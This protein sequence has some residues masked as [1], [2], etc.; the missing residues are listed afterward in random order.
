MAPEARCK[1]L[2]LSLDVEPAVPDAL[3]GDPVRLRQVVLN[4]LG[5][6][7]KFTVRGYIKVVVHVES[8]GGCEVAL[9]CSVRDSGIGVP[10]AQQELIF[11]PFYQVDGAAA[12]KHS[13]T[14]LGLAIASRLVG[15][16]RG[17]IWLESEVGHGSAFHFTACLGLAPSWTPGDCGAGPSNL[18]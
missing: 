3:L 15:D 4:I 14:G 2:E 10:P 12:R 7:V 17:R 9:R 8:I 1:D 6:A 18:V 11:E 5:N 16:L 13:G